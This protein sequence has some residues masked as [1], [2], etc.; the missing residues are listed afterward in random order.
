[1]CRGCHEGG[2]GHCP[3]AV[4]S[5]ITGRIAIRACAYHCT[6][7]LAE[8]GYVEGQNVAIEYR[9]AEN[10]TD[11]L[12]MLATDLIGREVTV[13]VATGGNNSALVAKELASTIPIVFTSGVDPVGAGL[14]A[15]LNRPEGNVTGVS[16]FTVELG[17][18]HIELLHELVPR[19]RLVAL[20]VRIPII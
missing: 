20:L 6:Y 10:N 3:K 5:S 9:F 16:W 7:G 13:I 1:V 14:V 15:S 11:R 18:K 8:T 17:A 2:A 12:R 4:A 19:A